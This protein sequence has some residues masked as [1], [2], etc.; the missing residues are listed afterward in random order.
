[1]LIALD[2]L[3]FF[4]QQSA[5]RGRRSFPQLPTRFQLARVSQLIH[6]Y[7]RLS[8][9]RAD[10]RRACHCVI[11]SN[12]LRRPGPTTSETSTITIWRTCV[13]WLSLVQ[14]QRDEQVR[15]PEYARSDGSYEQGFG[16]CWP[17]A[18]QLSDMGGHSL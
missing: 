1:M 5:F 10:Y 12:L 7:L 11:P 4:T 16:V 2:R 13:T 18:D 14:V 17:N 6:W 3:L 9:Q 15:K 8:G